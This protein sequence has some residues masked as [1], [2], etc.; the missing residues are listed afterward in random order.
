MK[1]DGGFVLVTGGA[2][3]IGRAICQELARRGLGVVVHYR[4]SDEEATRLVDALRADGGQVFA[5]QGELDSEMACHKL[6][7]DAFELTG[8]LVGLV[9]NASVFHKD[10]LLEL[11]ADKL[12]SEFAINTFAPVYLTKTFA[13]LFQKNTDGGGGGKV[14]NLLDRRVAQYERG[15]LAY[16][17]SKKSL[18][19]FTKLA[20][21][22]LAPHIT[23]NA[24]A[25]GAV[26]PPPGKGDDYIHDLAGDIPLDERP[27]P[28]AVARAVVYLLESDCVTGQT[29]FVD[30]GQHLV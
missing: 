7:A 15:M 16:M 9:N 28:E 18:A 3:R 12:E 26:L 1:A 13:E 5:L 23:V 8:G 24:V 11:S 2:V 29:I 14:I 17:M 30:G 19:D 21:L 4:R 22:E 20:A 6:I 27:T 10:A 25:P